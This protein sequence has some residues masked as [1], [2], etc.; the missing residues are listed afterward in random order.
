MQCALPPGQASAG[1]QS[2]PVTA[3]VARRCW[4]SLF[5]AMARG[6]WL[7]ACLLCALAA[8][9]VVAAKVRGVRPDQVDKYK[10]NNGKFTCFDG[11]K[12]I[13]FNQVNDNFCD[14]ADGTDEPGEFSTPPATH[15]TPFSAI[16]Q[17][18]TII[19]VPVV[20]NGGGT[21]LP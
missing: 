12:T 17:V 11:A 3:A 20:S 1:V 14:C 9:R 18:D 2:L 19:R 5:A 21:H 8:H 13:D 16:E 7:I 15:W 4:S 6:A 10:P